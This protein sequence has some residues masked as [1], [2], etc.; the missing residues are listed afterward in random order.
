M[1]IDV[2]TPVWQCQGCHTRFGEDHPAALRCESAPVP[3][4]LPDGTP[5]LQYQGSTSSFVLWPLLYTGVIETET[6]SFNTASGHHRRYAMAPDGRRNPDLRCTDAELHPAQ[7][8]HLQS[9]R[10]SPLISSAMLA[11]KEPP[12]GAELWYQLLDLG[13]PGSPAATGQLRAAYT[14]KWGITPRVGVA[15]PIT[16]EIRAVLDAFGATIDDWT[17]RDRYRPQSYRTQLAE[18][19]ALFLADG[20]S[21]RGEAIVATHPQEQLIA[22]CLDLQRRWF[23]GEQVCA[24]TRGM[25]W[26]PARI[27][28]TGSKLNK[29][30]R[31][32]V[33]AT[34]VPWPPRTDIDNYIGILL[35]DKL[36]HTLTLDTTKLFPLATTVI[37]VGGG[38]G[39]VGKSTT[40]AALAIAA[41]AAGLPVTLIDLDLNGPSQQLLFNLGAPHV[42]D[43][44]TRIVPTQVRPRL[45]V[46]SHGQIRDGLPT[47]WSAALRDSWIR[48]LEGTLETTD[49]V[50]LDLPAGWT[51]DTDA[52]VVVT[53]AHPL[54]L[55]DTR[56]RI[57]AAAGRE[58][59]PRRRPTYLLENLSQARGTAPDGT[60]V[61]VR[62]LGADDDVKQLAAD[63]D[64]TYSGS[65]PWNP[66][67]DALAAT[68]P[69]R[70]LA[71]TIATLHNRHNQDQ[72]NQQGEHR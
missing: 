23:L 64:I 25:A 10:N 7:A 68:E 33:A 19:Y 45:G 43:T 16:A 69:L 48:F 53:T 32:I 62:I 67:L 54:A 38:K 72:P 14:N 44:N 51:P 30:E 15:A 31:E 65:L 36:M 35:R 61:T 70:Q 6:S 24:P 18:G 37:G 4:V 12:A 58:D 17:R 1:P 28:K 21:R 2:S 63:T 34:G 9:L 55:S 66:D 20:D 47:Y 40:A 22:D 49:V 59:S 52:S 3:P 50:I 42:D 26:R 29:A 5:L 60:Q 46:F 8:G 56:R 71:A 39:G 13:Q 11:R 27:Q 57:P 41:A